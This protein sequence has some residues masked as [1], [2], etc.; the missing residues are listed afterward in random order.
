MLTFHW[1]LPPASWRFSIDAG[2]KPAIDT[3]MKAPN[4]EFN[5][6][7]TRGLVAA[8]VASRGA[9]G[10]DVERI[11][12]AK[13]DFAVAEAYFAPAEVALLKR[14]PPADRPLFFFRLWT[15][16]E[17]YV[18]AIGAGLAAPLD[19]FAFTL[20]PIDIAFRA[21]QSGDALAWQF[22]MAP[23]T[24]QHVLSVAV[25]RPPGEAA[26]LQSRALTPRDL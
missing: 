3:R 9:I 12:E 5:L 20:E 25:G 13:A 23:T 1:G 26:R 15:L 10:V 7:H 17:A 24:D 16:K 6:S 14:A 19:S 21:G 8:A 18:K 11:D 4:I 2:G 22:A